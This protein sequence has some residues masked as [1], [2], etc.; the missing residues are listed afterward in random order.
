[1]VLGLILLGLFFGELVFIIHMIPS[2]L[3]QGE[4]CP[5]PDLPPAPTPI[6]SEQPLLSEI[7]T[8]LTDEAHQRG[9]PEWVLKTIAKQE[10][11]WRQV[12]QSQNSPSHCEATGGDRACTCVSSS[13]DYGI[14][15][16]NWGV[17]NSSMD[18][19]RVQQGPHFVCSRPPPHVCSYPTQPVCFSPPRMYTQRYPACILSATQLVCFSPP[20]MY[21]QWYHE[22]GH[23][24]AE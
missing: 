18:W 11:N 15:Q 23:D 21:A 12:D 1:M 9:W 16:L 10:S 17:H 14:M 19:D 24:D 5:R 2:V 7:N 20:G 3:A 22:H 8:V 6:V 4:D 13:G